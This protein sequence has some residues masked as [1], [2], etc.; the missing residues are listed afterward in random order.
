VK[1]KVRSDGDPLLGIFEDHGG[2]DGLS[3][4]AYRATR[5]HIDALA[6]ELRAELATEPEP[7]R[8]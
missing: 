8:C 6:K 5:D 2:H 7:P 3:G 1:L 4:K